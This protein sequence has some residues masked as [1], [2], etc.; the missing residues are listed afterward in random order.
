MSRT[1]ANFPKLNIHLDRM[2]DRPEETL[3]RERYGLWISGKDRL[4]LLMGASTYLRDRQANVRFGNGESWDDFHGSWLVFEG[5]SDALAKIS[6]EDIRESCL[7]YEQE[8]DFPRHERNSDYELSVVAPDRPGILAAVAEMLLKRKIG[9]LNIHTE[10][11]RIPK[12]PKLGGSR[13]TL[14]MTSLK[15]TLAFSNAKEEETLGSLKQG[16]AYLE[17]RHHWVLELKRH[18]RRK[19]ENRLIRR[20]TPLDLA[21]QYNHTN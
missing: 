5:P 16:L 12:P 17:D 2:S 9:I 4:G 20:L 3:G 13:E 8:Y 10:S 11:L 1:I 15:M 7:K 21:K 19:T 6:E 14:D 18:K